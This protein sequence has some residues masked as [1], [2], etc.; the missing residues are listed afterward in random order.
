MESPNGELLLTV[1]LTQPSTPDGRTT[2]G[3]RPYFKL[4]RGASGAR[5]VVL[6]DSPMGIRLSDREFLENLEFLSADPV[7]KLEEHYTMPHGKRRECSNECNATTLRLRN[8]AGLVLEIDLR[9]YN[10]GVA[11]RY[12]LPGADQA[13]HTLL[14]EHTGFSLPSSSRLWVQPYDETATH[15]PAYEAFYEDGIAAGT[16]SHANGW[17]FP[18]LFCTANQKHWALITEANTTANFCAT[19]LVNQG[20][21]DLYRVQLPDPRDGNRAGSANPIARL[22]WEMPWRVIVVGGSP[23][24]IVE[25]TLVTDLSQPSTLTDTSWIHPGRVAW[26]WWSNQRSP[27]DAKAQMQFIDL[28]AEMGW[29]YVLVDANWPIMDNGN[30]HEVI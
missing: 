5:D 9:A 30:I 18:L 21:D 12:R 1:E 22:P 29:E 3:S 24:T 23:G 25:S 28:A 15:S 27:K 11:F 6:R 4:E 2:N 17:A 26:S 20:T 14:T 16:P 10:D 8:R 13:L 19:R 7:K